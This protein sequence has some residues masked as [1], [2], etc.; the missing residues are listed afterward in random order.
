[1]RCAQPPGHNHQSC[2]TQALG[3]AEG[4]CRA[5]GVRLTSLRRRVLERVWASPRPQGAYALLDALNQTP[6]PTATPAHDAGDSGAGEVGVRDRPLAP[7][8]VY[9][10]LDFL[11]EQGLV[12][13]LETLNAYIGCIQPEHA[14]HAGQFF[15]CDLCGVAAEIVDSRV[16][17][18]IAAVAASTGFTVSG[19]PTVEVRGICQDCHDVRGGQH[20]P[21]YAGDQFQGNQA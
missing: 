11:L 6:A 14:G 9:R 13:R 15:V 12:H 8:S 10:A 4:L 19:A 17:A 3:Q 1:M 2:I 20:D 7:L 21:H 5:R 18:A 16:D